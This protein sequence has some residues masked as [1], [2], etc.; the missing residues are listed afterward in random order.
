MSKLRQFIEIQ[1]RVP[2]S[3]KQERD[4]FISRCEPLNLFS[5]GKTEAEAL[6]NIQETVELFVESCYRRGTLEQVLKDC[7]FQPTHGRPPK[8]RV[9]QHMVNVPLPLV[10]SAKRAETRV[11]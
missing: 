7:G 8:R 6:E 1:I 2:V 5:Q 11:C 10:A 4:W 3:V 9:E